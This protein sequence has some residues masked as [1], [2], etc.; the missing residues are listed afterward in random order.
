MQFNS[1]IFV[2][3]LLPVSVVGYFALNK[4]THTAG[5]VF[6]TLVSGAFYLYGGLEGTLILAASMLINYLFSYLVSKNLRYKTA[7]FVAGILINAFLL[8]YFK[9]YNFLVENLSQHFQLNLVTK[10][11]LLPLGISFYTFQ[12]VAW[13]VESYRG[14]TQQ[15]SFLDYLLYTLYFPKLIMGPITGP[16]ELISQ[17]HNPELKKPD[18][19]QLMA[20]LQMFAFGMFKKVI[21]ADTFAKAVAWGFANESTATSGDL[22][23][24]MLAYTF[25]IYFDFSGYSDMALGVS[26]MLNIQ[27]AMN[28]DSPYQAMSIRD[29]WKRWHMS[30]TQFLTKYIYFPLGGSRKGEARTYLNTMLVF[31]FSGIWHGANWTFLLWGFLHGA[32]SVLERIF[33]KQYQKLHPGFQWLSTFVCTNVLWLLFT[34]PSIQQWLSMLGK[35]LSFQD[36]RITGALL[37]S[38]NMAEFDLLFRVLNVNSITSQVRGLS[39]LI[40]MV[41]SFLLCLCATNNVR[42]EKRP[43]ASNMVLCLVALTWSIL[44]LSGESTFLYF[45]F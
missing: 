6:L 41:F 16:Q 5:L 38:V 24:V 18:S 43:T 22:L 36:M 42:R 19:E 28:F 15:Y 45:G 44:S 11:L 37:R 27:L 34:S 17:F 9:Y 14:N 39:M 21:L 30:L 2:L 8:L 13:L 3:L 32:L 7:I 40:L 4:I 10:Q 1:Y 12:L 35:I 29:F 31:L 23:I 25:Q 33:H 26:K 20:G